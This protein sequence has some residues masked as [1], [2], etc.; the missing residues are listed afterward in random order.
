[1]QAKDE[2]VGFE[3]KATAKTKPPAKGKKRGDRRKV[4][5]RAKGGVLPI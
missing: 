1:L 5:V 3:Q 2:R 4:P